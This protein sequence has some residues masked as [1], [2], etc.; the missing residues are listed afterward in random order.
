MVDGEVL[1]H[2]IVEVLGLDGVLLL[3]QPVHCIPPGLALIGCHDVVSLADV[4][5]DVVLGP[6]ASVAS[7]V[8]TALTGATC[9]EY[10]A[11][12]VQLHKLV[13]NLD[14]ASLHNTHSL[15][16]LG[17]LPGHDVLD[18]LLQLK[19]G[20]SWHKHHGVSWAIP[21]VRGQVLLLLPRGPLPFPGPVE[22][23]LAT[24]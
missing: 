19:P 2:P 11:C 14:T 8:Q 13:L 12:Q 10:A 4:A 17:R 3:V 6:G 24:V 20:G 15:T 23:Y 21:D 7:S 5:C 18:L 9:R 1:G 22:W 16:E